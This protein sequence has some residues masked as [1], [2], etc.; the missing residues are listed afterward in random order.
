MKVY[1]SEILIVSQ[2]V[3]FGKKFCI[4]S[5]PFEGYKF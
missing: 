5:V 3:V 4:R 2:G 1:K